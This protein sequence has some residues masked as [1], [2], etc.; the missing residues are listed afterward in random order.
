MVSLILKWVSENLIW[1]TPL[2]LY[3]AYW[4]RYRFKKKPLHTGDYDNLVSDLLDPLGRGGG[5]REDRRAQALARLLSG[6][7]GWDAGV[8]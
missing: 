5:H 6:C 3:A 1:L 7:A 2:A 4:L 8:F